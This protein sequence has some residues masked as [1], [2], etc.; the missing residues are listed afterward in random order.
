MVPSAVKVALGQLLFGSSAINLVHPD[1]HRSLTELRPRWSANSSHTP[2]DSRQPACVCVCVCMCACVCV[3][4]VCV[5]CACVCVV[6]VHVCVVRVR[7][8]KSV[9]VCVCII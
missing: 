1:S 3:R 8:Y 4:V 7:E 6:C 2:A 5:L 9:C